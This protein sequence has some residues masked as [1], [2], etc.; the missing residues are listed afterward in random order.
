MA[1]GRASQ[2]AAREL[3]LQRRVAELGADHLGSYL[4][5]AYAA[6]ASLQAL[7]AAT[8]LGQASLRSALARAAVTVRLPGV[9]TAGG[10]RSRALTADQ[11]AAQRVG[12]ADL[13]VWLAERHREGW[14]LQQLAAAV[15]HSSHWVGWRL[16]AGGAQAQA[17]GVA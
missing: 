7:A 5:D 2:R 9:N 16:A 4:R 8:G 1:A 10:R 15:G 17:A 6:G 11:E 12:V 13:H 3:P 14:S